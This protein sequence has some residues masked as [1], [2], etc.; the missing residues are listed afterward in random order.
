MND[1]LG[2]PRG[3]RRID[4]ERRIIRLDLGQRDFFPAS[5]EPPHGLAHSRRI[6]RR[7]PQLIHVDD[8]RD[9]RRTASS[10]TFLGGH[11]TDAIRC[12]VDPL[13]DGAHALDLLRH[14]HHDAGAGMAEHVV[15]IIV[16]RRGIQRNEQRTRLRRGQEH[17]NAEIRVHGHDGDTIAFVHAPLDRCLGQQ[18]AHL[19]QRGVGPAAGFEFQRDFVRKDRCSRG[20]QRGNGVGVRRI[21]RQHISRRQRGSP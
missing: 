19:I 2:K 9:T 21:K 10:G 6:V 18:R 7:E 15:Q 4:H 5:D 17:D 3:A 13:D 8:A 16:G 14:R 12:F 11:R 1:A 20:Q